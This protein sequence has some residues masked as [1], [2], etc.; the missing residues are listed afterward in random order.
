[1]P[2]ESVMRLLFW[3]L[4]PRVKAERLQLL[5]FLY[6]GFSRLVVPSV[7]IIILREQ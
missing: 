4:I 7:T 3:S 5:S 2:N 6:C 1:M